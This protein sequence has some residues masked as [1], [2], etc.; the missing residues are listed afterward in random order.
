MTLS[1]K[2]G[3]TIIPLLARIV[4]GFAFITVGYA[5]VKHVVEYSPAQAQD[6]A[7]MG[8]ILEAGPAPAKPTDDADADANADQTGGDENAQSSAAPRSAAFALAS[9]AQDGDANNQAE[10]DDDEQAGGETVDAPTQLEPAE[11]YH[12][13]MKWNIALLL[14]KNNLPEP[15]L[16]TYVATWT[17]LVGGILILLGF[18][19]R[20]W[21]LG[22]AIAMGVAFYTTSMSTYFAG[23]PGGMFEIAAMDLATF[24]RV[25][26]QLSLFV[27]AFG[28]LLT[29]PGPVSIDRLIMPRKSSGDEY[30]DDD[31][32]SVQI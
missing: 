6:L 5:K 4:L 13:S 20:I 21:G 25:F 10:T 31:E 9:Y 23:F 1:Q 2:S 11:V 22:L 28:I 29:G 24:N 30:D 16:M 14:E 17:E 32:P 19:S 15:V 27:L 3:V 26:V 8:V 7:A 18:L 12:G